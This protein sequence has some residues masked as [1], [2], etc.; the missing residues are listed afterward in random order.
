MEEKGNGRVNN[1]KT[2]TKSI[3]SYIRGEERGEERISFLHE[4][5]GK[6][7]RQVTKEWLITSKDILL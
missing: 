2:A 5:F 7:R 1:S 3:G 4:D 6:L